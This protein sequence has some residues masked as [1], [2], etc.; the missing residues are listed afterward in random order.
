MKSRQLYFFAILLWTVTGCGPERG[1]IPRTHDGRVPDVINIAAMLDSTQSHKKLITLTWA[2][3]SVRYGTDREAANLRDWE[4]FRSFN[5]TSFFQSR[6]RTFFPTFSDSSNE[7]QPGARD[8]VVVLYKVY[9][10]GYLHDNIQFTG[11]PSDIVTVIVKN[12]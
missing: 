8:S 11:K 9:P 2:Y 3:D 5:D 4:V 10:S 6:G 1:L 12:N 7:I